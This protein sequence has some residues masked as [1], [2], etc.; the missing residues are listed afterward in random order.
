LGADVRVFRQILLGVLV[1]PTLMAPGLVRPA[2]AASAE[3]T[4]VTAF[5]D[6]YDYVGDGTNSLWRGTQQVSVHE[7]TDGTSQPDGIIEVDA[8]TGG[9]DAETL[10]FTFAAGHR[11]EL[12]AGT[13]DGAVVPSQQTGDQP[14]LF[15]WGNMVNRGS[16][17]GCPDSEQTGSFI[18]HDIAPDLS[19]LWISYKQHCYG[20]PEALYG[21]IRYREPG[22]DSDLLVAPTQIDWPAAYRGIPAHQ[23]PVTLV[24]TGAAPVHVSGASITEGTTEFSV[25]DNSCGTLAPGGSCAVDVSYEP[26]AAGQHHGQLT[27]QDSTTA[28]SQLVPLTGGIIPGYTSWT[29]R[30]QEQDYIEDGQHVSF[31]PGDTPVWARG[32]ATGV[33]IRT[34]DGWW[35]ASF[36]PPHGQVLRAG[37]TYTGVMRAPVVDGLGPGLDVSGD[38]RGCGRV[39]G[40]FHVRELRVNDGLVTAFAATFVQHCEGNTPELV[41]SIAWHASAPADPLPVAPRMAV[42]LSQAHIPPVVDGDSARVAGKIWRGNYEPWLPG[43]RIYVYARPRA[44]GPWKVVASDLTDD[45][46]SY[47]VRLPIH[48]NTDYQARF[49]G[50]RDHSPM[51]SPVRT[52]LA[53]WRTVLTHAGNA[54]GGK[55]RLRCAVVHGRRNQVVTL[56][57]LTAQ[58]HLVAVSTHRLNARGATYFI[59]KRPTTYSRAGYRALAKASYGR[60]PGPSP[61]VI[62][63]KG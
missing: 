8:T 11:A 31:T 52:S 16:E 6:R 20:Q 45:N 24:N 3:T 5:S 34:A 63:L 26:V 42:H 30:G 36:T 14:G 55:V 1:V 59:V 33:D 35:D 10:S 54:P 56:Q 29:M 60:A 22:G 62:V 4:F 47:W 53:K 49:R 37:T 43:K 9:Q 38:G 13:Y 19:H 2:A 51:K 12:T 27:I 15:A 61:Y 17:R 46:G 58:G 23:V 28:G 48:R 25:A 18:V 32:D 39:T 7:E 41:G 57:H 44:G 40:S 50:D 21:E